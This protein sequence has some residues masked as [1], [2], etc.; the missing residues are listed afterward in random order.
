M[1]RET[2]SIRRYES[3]DQPE[4]VR[5]WLE[6]SRVGHPFLTEGDL[7]QQLPKVRD[8]Y[9]PQAETWVAYCGSLAA[10]FIGLLDNFIGGLFV[11]P[12]FH[13]SGVGRQL[14]QHA[15]SLKPTLSVDVYALNPIAPAFYQRLGFREV[16]RRPQ[17]DEGRPLEIIHMVR[18]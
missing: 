10:G 9:L 4:M 8:T 5:I 18:P 13:A 7:H 11:D 3:A 17:D 6:A 16:S 12:Q 15:A 1:T 2:L 14:I